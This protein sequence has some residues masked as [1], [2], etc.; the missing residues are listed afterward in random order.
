MEETE[1]NEI[2]KS[3]LEFCDTFGISIENP[4]VE[5]QFMIFLKS[6]MDLGIDYVNSLYSR[7]D[8]ACFELYGWKLNKWPQIQNSIYTYKNSNPDEYR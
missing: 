4:P 3:W 8:K 2:I 6:K 5:Y 1:K 7:I